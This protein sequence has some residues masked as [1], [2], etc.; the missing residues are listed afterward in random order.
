MTFSPMIAEIYA[1]KDISRLKSNYQVVTKLVFTLSLLVYA[2]I[3]LFP[4]ELLSVFGSEFKKA[5]PVL[6]VLSMGQLINAS[7]G[8]TGRMLVMTGHPKIELFNS[9]IFVVLTI[10]LNLIL[11]PRYNV[12]GAGIANAVT[13]SIV[14]LS[15]VIQIYRAV[16]IHPFRRD[17]LKPLA[18]ILLSVPIIFCLKKTI[19]LNLLT[20]FLLASVLAAVYFLIIFLLGIRPE[21]R[22]ILSQIKKGLTDVKVK[23]IPGRDK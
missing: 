1:K 14:N 4:T 12:L 11:I 2:I 3:L 23:K 7:V 18:A 10:L 22:W 13:L 15:R 9:I 19:T 5:A 6:V 17:Y 8:A 20:C 16:R 21:E